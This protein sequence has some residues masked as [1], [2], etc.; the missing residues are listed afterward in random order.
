[1]WADIDNYSVLKGNISKIYAR[2]ENSPMLKQRYLLDQLFKRYVIINSLYHIWNNHLLS[3]KGFV[4]RT[5]KFP[6]ETV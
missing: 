2:E 6:L 1:M 4:T 5:R 3:Q